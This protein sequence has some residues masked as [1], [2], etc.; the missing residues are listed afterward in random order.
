M[1]VRVWRG[2][3]VE[4]GYGG[5]CGGEGEGVEVRV[6]RGVCSKDKGVRC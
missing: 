1:E 3:C 2:G 5:G 6:W 4:G